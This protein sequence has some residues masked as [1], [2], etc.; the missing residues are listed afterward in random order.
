METFKC[1]GCG[2][3]FG[4]G[5]TAYQVRAGEA[6]C[7]PDEETPDFWQPSEDVG[8]YCTTCMPDLPYPKEVRD[9]ESA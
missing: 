2:K 1:S 8:Y 4:D 3:P 7:D 9:A 6:N 5:Q